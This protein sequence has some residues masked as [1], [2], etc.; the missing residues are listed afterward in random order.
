[1]Q[2]VR[3]TCGTYL[4]H[5]RMTLASST[6]ASFYSLFDIAFIYLHSSIIFTDSG[7]HLQGDAEERGEVLQVMMLISS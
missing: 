2:T 7:E 4:H 3:I 1:M 6:L 5:S